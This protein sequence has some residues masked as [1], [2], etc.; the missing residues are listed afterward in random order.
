MHEDRNVT[1]NTGCIGSLLFVDYCFGL[2]HLDYIVTL[3]GNTFL[4]AE[5]G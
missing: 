3:P 2:P 5:I 4:V 1:M